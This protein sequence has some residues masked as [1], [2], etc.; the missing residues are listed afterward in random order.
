MKRLKV[1]QAGDACLIHG[2]KYNGS[3]QAS[4]VNVESKI[5]VRVWK[6]NGVDIWIYGCLSC[7]SGSFKESKDVR[8]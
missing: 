2:C 4:R 3:G 7:S 6:G 8:T 1:A 5:I